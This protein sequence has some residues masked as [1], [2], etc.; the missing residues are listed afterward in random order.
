MLLPD[1]T[2]QHNSHET[3]LQTLCNVG[4]QR[5]ADNPQIMAYWII[6]TSLLPCYRQSG[7]AFHVRLYD[8]ALVQQSCLVI[9]LLFTILFVVMEKGLEQFTGATSVNTPYW[10]AGEC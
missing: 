3:L 8:T 4:Y 10:H 6:N 7:C 2:T 1:N 5:Q 9:K